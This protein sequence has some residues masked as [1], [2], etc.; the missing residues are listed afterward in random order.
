MPPHEN[1]LLSKLPKAVLAEITAIDLPGEDELR[2]KTL[3]VCIGRTVELLQ[4]GDPLVIRVAGTSIGISR[5][6]ANGVTV[7]PQRVAS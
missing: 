1:V 5:R 4:A 7:A 2:M 6:L 3:G